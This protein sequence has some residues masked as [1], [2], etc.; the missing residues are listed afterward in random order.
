MRIKIASRKSDLARIQA[1]TVGDILTQAFP[2]TQVEYEFSSSL[3]DQNLD[4]PLWTMG[5]KGVFTQDFH[6]GLLD[7]RFDLVVHSW[8]D[9]PTEARQGTRIVGTLEREDARDV[10][11]VSRVGWEEVKKTGK[12]ILL[13]SSP[14][15]MYNLENFVKWALPCE[16]KEVEFRDVRGNVPTRIGKLLSGQGHALIAAKAGL[17]R[18]LSAQRDEFAEMQKGLRES[19]AQ[20]RWMVLPLRENPS[21]AAQGALAFEV[22]EGRDDL[23]QMLRK[24]TD[25]VSEERVEEER[26]ILSSHGGG[27]HQKIGVT[28]LQRDFGQILSLRGLTEAGVVLNEFRVT[29]PSHEEIPQATKDQISPLEPKDSNWFERVPLAES[30]WR[31]SLESS[32]ALWVARDSSLPEEA[33]LSEETFVWAAGVKTW[34]KLADRG[35]WVHGSAES[36]GEREEPLIDELIGR[37]L[38]WLKLTHQDAT[39]LGGYETLATYKLAPKKSHPDLSGKTHFYWMSGSSFQQAVIY[40]PWIASSGYHAC[41]PG[42]TYDHLKTQMQP[43][44]HLSVFLDHSTWLSTVLKEKTSS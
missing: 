32:E 43:G 23:I 38:N 7:G 16:I 3:G 24:I 40:F 25:T 21:A 31:S 4:D 42:H 1:Y 11:L 26:R 19:L 14:R 20:C 5:D 28:S 8:K 22:K 34:A 2:D 44:A 41:G 12:L 27:C 37:S 36:L 33:R 10:L 6:A 13:T 29:H 30:E 18:L 9:L 35:I 15:R 17:D 39:D